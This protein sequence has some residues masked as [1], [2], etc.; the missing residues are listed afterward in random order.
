MPF[1]EPESGD[2]EHG[3]GGG[4][5]SINNRAFSPGGAGGWRDPDRAVFANGAD[6]WMVSTYDKR[7]GAIARVECA[8]V[9]SPPPKST[10]AIAPVDFGGGLVTSANTAY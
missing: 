4:N 6:G 1:I 2:V 8:D 5:A 9:T 10:R 3:V 7:T